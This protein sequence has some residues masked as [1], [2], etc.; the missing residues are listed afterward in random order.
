MIDDLVR[1]SD[2][3]GIKA[4]ID[5]DGALADWGSAQPDMIHWRGR[6]A[7]RA[8]AEYRIPARP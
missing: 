3:F 8:G 1:S 6:R 4:G 7:V 2:H 5:L